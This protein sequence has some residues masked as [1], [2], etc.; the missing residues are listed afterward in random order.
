MNNLRV[1]NLAIGIAVV[2][3][4]A[5]TGQLMRHY[6]HNADAPD[7]ERLYRRSRHLFLLLSGLAQGGIGIY[8]QSYQHRLSNKI[9]W[10]ATVLMA[11]GSFSLAYA[12]FYEI[13]NQ[14][15]ETPVSRFAMYLLLAGVVLHL[16]SSLPNQYYQS[17]A[18]DRDRRT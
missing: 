4:F 6:Y 12:F 5:I 7:L 2:I 9:Q 1:T 14:I 3:L 13:P 8:I 17:K 10:I 11:L 15:I 16:G 18:I